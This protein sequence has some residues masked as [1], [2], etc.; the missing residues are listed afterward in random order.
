MNKRSKRLIAAIIAIL[1]VNGLVSY[2]LTQNPEAF[3]LQS[4]LAA[5]IISTL[6]S[7]LLFPK[8]ESV[9]LP[10]KIIT[11]R[12]LFMLV[13][14]FVI[15]FICIGISLVGKKYQQRHHP[16]TYIPL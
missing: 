1:G 9:L 8:K 15:T 5:A 4:V 2:L 6:I 3:L 10:L 13:I 12:S 7:F 16:N 14:F 11:L